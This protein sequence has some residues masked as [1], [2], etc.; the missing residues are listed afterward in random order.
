MQEYFFI[1]ITEPKR[2]LPPVYG[3]DATKVHDWDE[4][5][6]KPAINI[7]QSLLEVISFNFNM[8]DVQK[9]F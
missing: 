7:V 3:L 6:L 1:I 8:M 2:Q 5:V 4:N 9:W